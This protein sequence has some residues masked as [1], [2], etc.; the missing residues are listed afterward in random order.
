MYGYYFY[1]YLWVSFL[2]IN[3][4]LKSGGMGRGRRLAPSVDSY[5][6][7]KQKIILLYI[8][9]C[10]LADSSNKT[11][12]QYVDQ[13]WSNSPAFELPSDRSWEGICNAG[14]RDQALSSHQSWLSE[15]S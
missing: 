8:R 14:K 11:I 10:L 7:F 13:V 3:K 9:A 12:Y 6:A 2:E 5:D 15:I 4:S 1:W